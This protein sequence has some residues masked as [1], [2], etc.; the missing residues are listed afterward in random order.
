MLKPFDYAFGDKNGVKT[1]FNVYIRCFTYAK[2]ESE[3]HA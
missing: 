1:R 2:D 3:V